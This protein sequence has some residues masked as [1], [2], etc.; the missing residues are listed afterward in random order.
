[1]SARTGDEDAGEQ[2]S[3]V[4]SVAA[5]A[6]R[7][8]ACPSARCES[9]AVLL[10]IALPGGKLAYA[11]D[12][13][14]IDQDFVDA[15]KS[16]GRPAEQRFRFSSACV[17]KGCRQWVAGRCGVIDRVIDALSAVDDAP[18]EPLPVDLPQCSIRSTCR[19]FAQVG[20]AACGVCPLII[21]DNC[22][23]EPVNGSGD[24]LAA[25]PGD[26]ALAEAMAAAG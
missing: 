5:V 7:H 11:S 23:L 14:V 1:M 10:A 2:R 8:H 9:G 21:T 4:E 6:H 26:G 16:V 12:R 24:S 19:W 20:A 18:A 13:I 22:A 25:A 15:A 3:E 17:E